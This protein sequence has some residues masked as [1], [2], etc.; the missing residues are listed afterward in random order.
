MVG[1]SD[2]L[3]KIITL[4][5]VLTAAYFNVGFED[6]LSN[7]STLTAIA[8]SFVVVHLSE[9]IADAAS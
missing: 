7:C 9:T 6:P 8:S 3:D 2:D 4:F 5:K 1:Q